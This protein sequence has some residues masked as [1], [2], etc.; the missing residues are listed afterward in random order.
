MTQGKSTAQ[1]ICT[2]NDAYTT[3]SSMIES[4][5]H[6][7]IQNAT[8][9]CATQEEQCNQKSEQQIYTLSSPLG[10]ITKQ[11]ENFENEMTHQMIDPLE[12]SGSFLTSKTF[13]AFENKVS[14]RLSEIIQM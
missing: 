6:K 5:V 3:T 8:N 11:M 9:Q 4:S 10:T 1:S 2:L 14:K 12:K 7:L 13:Y